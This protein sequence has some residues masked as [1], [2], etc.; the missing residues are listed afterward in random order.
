MSSNSRC[1]ICGCQVHRSGE[2]AVPTIA[3]RSH[4]TEHHYVAER[5]FGRSKNR[6]GVTRESIFATCPWGCEKK[7]AVYCYECHEELLHNPVLLPDDIVA[8]AQLVQSRGL[9]EDLKSADRSKLAG[10]VM[11]LHE[12]ISRGLAE[13]LKVERLRKSAVE[14]GSDHVEVSN[15]H[16]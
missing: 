10:R 15:E 14:P 5:F 16:R 11:L 13:I 7:T 1:A 12:V 2:Y 8:F 6:R 9:G 3:G 4:A